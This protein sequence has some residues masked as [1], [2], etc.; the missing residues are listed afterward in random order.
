MSMAK[1]KTLRD[2]TAEYRSLVTALRNR[3]QSP[4]PPATKSKNPQALTTQ[5]KQRIAA[6][7]GKIMSLQQLQRQQNGSHGGHQAIEHHSNVVLSL[8]SQLASTS[9]VFKDVLELRSESLKESGSRKEQ[10]IGP[11]AAAASNVAFSPT[12][13]HS[14]NAEARR[15]S[16]VGAPLHVSASAMMLA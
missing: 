8:Q 12:G 14:A 7:N 2:R 11:A 15:H 13:K 4:L 5:V 16:T 6:I 10:F 1:A 9:T 3:Q